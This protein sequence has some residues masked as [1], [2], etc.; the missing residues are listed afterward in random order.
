M[1]CTIH[2]Q[3]SRVDSSLCHCHGSSHCLG[4][5]PAVHR[6]HSEANHGGLMP[7]QTISL[8]DHGQMGGSRANR[9]VSRSGFERCTPDVLVSSC[10]WPSSQR[11]P[12]AALT[13]KDGA[14]C[15][16]PRTSQAK[17][18]LSSQILVCVSRTGCGIGNARTL[19]TCAV[20]P[21]ILVSLYFLTGDCSRDAGYLQTQTLL[22]VHA[23]PA[24][25]PH[26]KVSL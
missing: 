1:R 12:V 2:W 10:S 13:M 15:A 19:H 21:L 4:V 8:S 22:G 14:D 11:S 20:D 5:G 9:E 24:Q 18:A 16:T 6:L 25:R 26:Y 23:R 3:Q 7:Y 17:T